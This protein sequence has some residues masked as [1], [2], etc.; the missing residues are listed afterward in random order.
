MSTAASTGAPASTGSASTGASSTGAAAFTWGEGW[1]SHIAAGT[2]DPEKEIKQLERYESPEQ[3][4]KK[5]R[6]LE[7]RL[8][9][10]EL[11]STLRKDAT[12]QEVAAWRTENGIPAK[13]E[14]YKVTMPAG[15][16]APKEDDA[17]LT[18]VR[19]TAHE[20]NYTQPQFDAMVNAFYNEVDRQTAAMGEAEKRLTTQADEKLRQEWGADYQTNKALVDQFYA[21]AP[22]SIR[23]HLKAGFLGNHTPIMASVEFQKFIVQMEREINPFA[24][25]VPGGSADSKTVDAR[26][27]ELRAM[28]GNQA[29]EYWEGPKAAGLQE[30]YRGL[31]AARDKMKERQAA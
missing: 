13:P 25:V 30:E 29:S 9:R 20:Q 17:F 8:S 22:E 6:E 7:G 16:T 26:I 18:K 19:Q 31:V 1:R 10:G 5:A 28:M 14:E 27:N 4:W 24:T 11:R 2:T 15:K 12:A 21:R 3:V 23:E